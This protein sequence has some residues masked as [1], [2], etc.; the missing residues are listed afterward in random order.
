MNKFFSLLQY[1]IKSVCHFVCK[2]RKLRV[3]WWTV[4]TKLNGDG[5]IPSKC[6]YWYELIRSIC[7]LVF[8]LQNFADFIVY[9]L[10][11]NLTSYPSLRH[12]QCFPH[13]SCIH[14]HEMFLSLW[15]VWFVYCITSLL[16]IYLLCVFII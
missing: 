4:K 15:F 7:F 12:R 3:G 9:R 11:Q 1:S 16:H 10:V 5:L 6:Q 2:T 13:D 14:V 8:Y